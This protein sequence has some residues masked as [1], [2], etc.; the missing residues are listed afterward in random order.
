MLILFQILFTL[1]TLYALSS[2]AARKRSGELGP[3]GL[4]F[5]MLFWILATIFVWYPEATNQLAQT[6]GIGRG[7]DFV[8]Y[9]SLVTI[10][11]VLFRLHVKLE[12]MSRD[13]TKLVREKALIST[14]NS[15]KK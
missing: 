14:Q 8:L 4:V 7:T 6:F 1:F 11:F 2:V 5:W 3:R 15:S 10:F 13:V 9:V 12:S